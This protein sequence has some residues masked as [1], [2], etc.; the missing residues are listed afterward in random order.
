MIMR[1]IKYL[2]SSVILLAMG[3][4]SCQQEDQI[5]K[6]VLVSESLLEI[7]A[8]NAED[9]VVTVYSDGQWR[10]EAPEWITVTPATGEGCMDVTL[11]FNDNIRDGAVDNPRE[12]YVVFRGDRLMSYAKVKVRQDGDKFRDLAAV[13]F[14]EL[15]DLKQETFVMAEEALVVAVANN[16]FLAFADD[17]YVFVASAEMP[18]IGDKVSFYAYTDILHSFVS[19]KNAERVTIL[20]S[21]NPVNYTENDITASFD[22]FVPTAVSYITLEGVL[23]GNALSVNDA[24]LASCVLE[25][26]SEDLQISSLNGHKVRISGFAM[27]KETNTVYLLPV[28]PV[29]D[30]GVDEIIYF[31]DNFDWVQPFVE[32]DIAQGRT[33]GDSM[34]DDIQYTVSSS[35]DLAGFEEAFTNM[36]YEALFPASKAIYVMK[37][38]Y[39]KFS[40]GKN[41][42]GIRLPAMELD[43]ASSVVLSFDWGINIGSG[44][45]DK[46]ELEVEIEGAG[47]I[48]GANK[49]APIVHTAGDWEWQ[50][51]TITISGLDNNSRITIKP[52]AFTGV[53]DATSTYYR[54]F[55]DNVKVVLGEGG[56]V[57][58]VSGEAKT[59]ATFPFP[60]DTEFTGE[61]EGAGTMWNL[62]EGWLLSEDANSKLS[63]HNADDSQLKVTYK[64]EASS[65]EGLTKDHVRI[66]A[67]GMVKGSYWLF[68]VPVK[69]MPAG[70]YN[71]TYNH[72]ASAT[73]PNYFLM[74]VSLDGQNWAPAGAQTTTETFKDGSNGREVTWTYALNRGGVNAANIAYVV[75]VDY[76]A[77]ALPGDNTLYIRAKVA[78]DM[79][80][81]S[82]KALGTKG[83]NRIWGPCEITFSN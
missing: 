70:T 28:G 45:P 19:L 81:G 59:L 57:P 56:A 53:K 27:G 78:D 23:N 72:S 37:G 68:E 55:L 76:A 50:T 34:L 30:N 61:G 32:D 8:E 67:T 58:P 21:S 35:Y 82:E 7:P 38:N 75:D 52:T 71:V 83:T 47:T 13:P 49:S 4:I 25:N 73:G 62:A 40:K 33:Q 29:V 63:A 9:V 48:G 54:W 2:F 6:A 16:G 80:Y 44:G 79:A 41:T 17:T 42:N 69:D 22:T 20:S 66:L 31:S 46:V 11:S 64:Y 36:G 14:T 74:E 43:G 12:E 18:E 51:E 15:A 65:D 26:P 10:T 3:L 1:N 5:A 24:V 77:P 39:L 60:Y